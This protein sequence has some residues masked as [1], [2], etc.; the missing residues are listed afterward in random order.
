MKTLYYSPL[1]IIYTII[2]SPLLLPSLSFFVL[3]N[4]IKNIVISDLEAKYT[5]EKNI[6]MKHFLYMMAF[7]KSWRNLFYH[8]CRMLSGGV[9]LRLFLPQNPDTFIKPSLKLGSHARFV[10]PHCTHINCNKIGD[11]FIIYHCV[12]I[13]GINGETPTIGNHVTIGCHS[14][15]LGGVKIGN[16]VNIGAGTIITKDIPDNCTVIGNHAY[17][18][19]LN[20]EQVSIKL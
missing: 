19:K 14:A 10:H 4:K 16:N 2:K 8:R 13:G 17:I 18:V 11:Y 5:G 1:Q 15:I 3:S 7:E 6:G 20:G 9:F 12:T